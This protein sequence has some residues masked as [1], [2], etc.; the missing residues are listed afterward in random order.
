MTYAFEHP[1]H[2]HVEMHMRYADMLNPRL[3]SGAGA[4]PELQFR[5]G[6]PL[7]YFAREYDHANPRH[8]LA[9]G[10]ASRPDAQRF[11]ELVLPLLLARA[12]K[13]QV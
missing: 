8:H 13:S 9:L 2:R 10:F 1:H 6:R 12:K 7:E 4:A 3:V 11:T 5:I